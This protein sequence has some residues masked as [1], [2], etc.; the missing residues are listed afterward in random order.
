MFS[1]WGGNLFEPKPYMVTGASSTAPAAIAV[2]EEEKIARVPTPD[3]VK[4][5]YMTACV[6]TA[7]SLRDKLVALVE[8]TELNSIVLDVKSY[9][10][11]ISYDVEDERLKGAV[12]GPC[13]VTDLKGLLAD[14]HEK[15]IYMIARVASFQDPVAVKAD[16][17]I[18]VKKKSDPNAIWKD[19]KG[20]TWID[21]GAKSHWEYLVL[22]AKDAYAIGFDEINFDYIR[23]PSDGNMSDI[24]YPE[25]GARK[26]AD[27]I[28]EFFSYLHDELSGTGMKISADLFGMVTTN[29]DDL[30]IGQVL[31]RALPYF[32][33]IAPMVYP[34]HYPKNFNG[35]P[36]PNKV[37]YEIIEYSMGEAALRARATS[38]PIAGFA[39]ALI[40]STT[41]ALYAK[42]PYDPKEKLRP[43]LQDN[44]YPVP[45]TPEMVRAQIQATYD[46]GL[47]SW[48]LWNAGNRYTREALLAE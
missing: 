31:E 30:N 14:L 10:G 19:H 40:P 15:G 37:P 9:D 41:P 29:K 6:A 27:V 5:I 28:E 18:A 45:Y 42:D 22:L 34:S 2:A 25:S 26:K 23:F 43:W 48:L 7:P 38:T 35:W 3:A 46:V 39:H 24:L 11:W 36:D 16:P 8:E 47:D 17:S 13:K 1:L 21:A 44:N 20:I 33:Y 32:D 12:G 4:G